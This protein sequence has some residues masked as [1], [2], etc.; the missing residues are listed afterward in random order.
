M[1]EFTFLTEK[2]IGA[3]DVMK[4][5]GTKV[6]QTDLASILSGHMTNRDD[7]TSEGDL[8]CT[9]WSASLNVY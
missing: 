2:Q 5:Y 3:L 8:T 1:P 4:R 7:R 9:S 6:A